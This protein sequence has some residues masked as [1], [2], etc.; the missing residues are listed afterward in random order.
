MLSECSGAVTCTL[1]V[2]DDGSLAHQIL[3]SFVT[4][5]IGAADSVPLDAAELD[6]AQ[7]DPAMN[8]MNDAIDALE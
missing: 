3:R 1:P 5:G 8:D 4:P 7:L 6:A 2:S